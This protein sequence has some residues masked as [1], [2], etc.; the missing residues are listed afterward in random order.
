M[1]ALLDLAIGGVDHCLERRDQVADHIFGR[2]VEQRRQALARRCGG[3]LQPVHALDEQRVLRDREGVVAEGLAVPAG[4][5][6]ETVR[7]ILDLDV[8][9]RRIE[10]VEATAR[11]HSL[12][13]ARRCAGAVGHRAQSS[14]TLA[15]AGQ[16]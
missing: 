13:C 10:Q 1:Q 12:P 3:V 5:P 2:I 6:G 11:Q 14:P 8:E 7:D 16:P 15:V 4:D 9:R